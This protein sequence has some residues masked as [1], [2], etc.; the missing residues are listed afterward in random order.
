MAPPAR[1]QLGTSGNQQLAR[2]RTAHRAR[3]RCD[4][5]KARLQLLTREETMGSNQYHSHLASCWRVTGC[6]RLSAPTCWCGDGS[7]TKGPKAPCPGCDSKFTRLIHCFSGLQYCQ[8]WRG[9]RG[10]VN[11]RNGHVRLYPFRRKKHF[12]RQPRSSIQPS[13]SL[14]AP[15]FPLPRKARRA[16]EIHFLALCSVE[17]FCFRCTARC[18]LCSWRSAETSPVHSNSI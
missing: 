7:G 14:L 2:A 10:L 5:R 9:L 3:R 1:T 17:R 15:S 6:R 16:C 11:A 13:S 18:V 12:V 4:T 8:K